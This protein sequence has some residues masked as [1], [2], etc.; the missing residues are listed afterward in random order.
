MFEM[1][2]GYVWNDLKTK[3]K[4]VYYS[5]NTFQTKDKMMT[6]GTLLKKRQNNNNRDSC[7]RHWNPD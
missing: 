1:R 6:V 7:K 2:N 4:L 5:W 3:R